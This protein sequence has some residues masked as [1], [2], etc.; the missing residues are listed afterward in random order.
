MTSTR[1][2][3]EEEDE[4]LFLGT[5]LGQYLCGC[6]PGFCFPSAVTSQLDRRQYPPEQNTPV[7]S[8]GQ[9]QLPQEETSAV[10]KTQRSVT[11]VLAE[12]LKKTFILPLSIRRRSHLKL[13]ELK[14][15]L[16]EEN[17]KCVS[18]SSCTIQQ[19]L[20]CDTLHSDPDYISH[21]ILG[22]CDTFAPARRGS[23]NTLPPPSNPDMFPSS[24]FIICSA[25]DVS[26][27]MADPEPTLD[28]ELS[29]HKPALQMSEQIPDLT[30]PRP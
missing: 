12:G 23:S 11:L 20:A 26:L 2:T 16:L 22:H 13:P 21:C 4:E 8:L 9:R 27:H 15:V 7:F 17:P 25:S 30:H 5:G 24:S 1:S 18:C 19:C 6:C 10:L 3:L 28:S 29:L 14:C